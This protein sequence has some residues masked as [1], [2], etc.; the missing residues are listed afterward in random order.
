MKQNSV[1]TVVS[2]QSA[3]FLVSGYSGSVRFGEGAV[4]K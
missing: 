1:A 2:C 4:I 3:Y